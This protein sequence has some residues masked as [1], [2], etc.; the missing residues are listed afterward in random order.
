MTISRLPP[1]NSL[2]AFDAVV[3]H[4]SFALAAQE[5]FVTPAA[6]SYQ[7]KQLEDFL[8]VKLFNR[9]N[10]S[11]ELTTHGQL[12]YPGVQ[13]AFEQLTQTMKLLQKKRSGDVLVISAGPSFT[14]KWLTPRLYR[15]LAK[16]PEIDARISSSM[17]VSNLKVDDVDIAI[18][19]GAGDY[20]DY[21]SVKLF[22]DYMAPMCSPAFLKALQ[23]L[24][25]E[26]LLEHTL[27]HD[28]T[29]IGENFSV[30]NWQDWFEHMGVSRFVPAK[31][32]LHFNATDNA[33][34]AAVS[35]AGI[36]LGRQV[37]AQADLDANRLVMPFEHKLKLDF[38]YYTL[39]LPSRAN[40]AHIKAFIDW[41]AQEINGDIDDNAPI[42]V[43]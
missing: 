6:L 28:D 21:D 37:A 39:C 8:D 41:L 42:P 34:S 10:R 1:L 15:F 13:Q 31:Q 26:G 29:H 23:P 43:F 7:I 18:R 3:R 40:E 19:F 27:I 32:G 35:G 16:H 14:A 25:V 24:T 5:L 22:D 20:P 36:V 17:K 2:K 12:I 30:A 4:M 9:L 33:I 38:S 11:I